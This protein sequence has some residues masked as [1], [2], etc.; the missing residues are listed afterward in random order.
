MT[1]FISSES[2]VDSS[3]LRSLQYGHDF[4]LK[5]YYDKLLAEHYLTVINEYYNYD[6][7]SRQKTL[8]V[9]AS[10]LTRYDDENYVLA[11]DR[12]IDYM[13]DIEF[14]FLNNE[15]VSYW[16]SPKLLDKHRILISKQNVDYY[17]KDLIKDGQL[18]IS[19]VEEPENGFP[20]YIA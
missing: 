8:P 13:H 6:I 2:E 7:D 20:L 18:K 12:P 10:K 4:G 19:C 14:V 17:L 11:T 3:Y 16:S 5:Q 1:V 9:L 15:P